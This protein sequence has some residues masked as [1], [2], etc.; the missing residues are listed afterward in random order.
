M[1]DQVISKINTLVINP[2]ILVLFAV[3]LLFF[4]WGVLEF[5]QGA[6]DPEARKVGRDHMLYGIIGL[7]VMISAFAIIRVVLTSFNIDTAPLD[8]IEKR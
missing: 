7:F 1:A 5:I 4:L 6:D 2:I 3:A 8:A